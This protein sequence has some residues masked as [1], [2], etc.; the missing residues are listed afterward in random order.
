MRGRYLIMT[1]LC[2]SLT[3]AA[4]SSVVFLGVPLSN[5]L[6]G[7]W[8]V[9]QVYGKDLS[10][11]QAPC[12]IRFDGDGRYVGRTNS[13]VFTGQWT[14]GR[15]QVRFQNL[16]PVPVGQVP[17]GWE[18][19]VRMAMNG[20]REARLERDALVLLHQGMPVARLVQQR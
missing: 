15:D 13:G 18:R 8:R 10:Q 6:L 2:W 20:L 12:L 7:Q 16:G 9:V 5:R 3:E 14:T 19:Q 11:V 4:F 17:P 1:L